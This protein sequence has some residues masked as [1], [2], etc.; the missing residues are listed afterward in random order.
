MTDKKRDGLPFVSKK[1]KFIVSRSLSHYAGGSGL[2]RQTG[3]SWKGKSK[4]LHTP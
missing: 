4:E 1:I 3:K 2:K